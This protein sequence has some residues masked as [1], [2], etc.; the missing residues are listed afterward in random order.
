MRAGPVTSAA[1]VLGTVLLSPTPAGAAAPTTWAPA[2]SATIHPG[3][4]TVTGETTCT[5]GFAFLDAAGHAYLAQAANC[6]ATGDDPETDGCSTKSLPLGTPVS[7]GGATGTLAYSS[8]LS[9]QKVRERDTD[10][11]NSNDFALIRLP[12]AAMAQTNPSVP[13]FGGPVKLRTDVAGEGTPTFAVGAS[14]LYGGPGPA[15]AKRGVIL[16]PEA[17]DW[18]YSV[19]TVLPGIPGDAGAG[20]LDGD[21]SAVGVV[22]SLAIAPLAGSNSVTNLATALA[23]AQRHSGIEGLRLVPGTEAF[24]AAGV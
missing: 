2:G 4:Q 15:A 7:V 22:A 21:G 5:A 1:V 12:D 6:A 16:G 11:C 17:G 14:P 3:I 20:Y 23:Y 19:Y 13:T 24:T 8:W 9:M 10:A 18:S